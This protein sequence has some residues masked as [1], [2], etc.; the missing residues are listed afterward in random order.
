V[1]VAGNHL[2]PTAY[3]V[4][5]RFYL[6]SPIEIH[7]SILDAGAEDLCSD[8]V[9]SASSYNIESGTSCGLPG[10]A[11]LHNQ[12]STDA[13]LLPNANNG[14]F[15]QTMAIP[16]N[17]PAVD[18]ANSIGCPATDQRQVLRPIDGNGDGIKGCDI[19]AFELGSHIFIPMI[20]K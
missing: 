10:A 16:N 12:S 8:A 13:L 6:A 9:S 7:N 17:S 19:G 11:G 20:T 5:Y 18:A 2:V 15:S 4:I 14:G 1:T 3:G